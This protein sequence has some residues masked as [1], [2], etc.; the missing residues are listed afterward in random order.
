MLPEDIE[1]FGQLVPMQ[2]TG[3]LAELAPSYVLLAS[4]EGSYMTG[5]MIAVAGGAVAI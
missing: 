2:R 1:S 4:D 5:V 3:Q